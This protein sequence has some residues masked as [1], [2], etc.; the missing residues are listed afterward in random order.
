MYELRRP[1]QQWPTEIAPRSLLQIQLQ[2]PGL[3]N[4]SGETRFNH[5]LILL[6]TSISSF[7][8]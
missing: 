6:C 4:N 5:L 1:P 3:R 8:I 7:R 2:S